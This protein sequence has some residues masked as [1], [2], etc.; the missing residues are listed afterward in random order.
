MNRK[1]ITIACALFTLCA[2]PVNGQWALVWEDDFT[3]DPFGLPDSSKWG[4]E[5]GF[6]RNNELQYYTVARTE[7]ARVENGML[8]IEGRKESYED[9]NYTSASMITKN[10]F[11]FTYG[12]VEME[13]KLPQGLGV[14]PALWTMGT[15]GI[16]P[17]LGEIDIMEYVGKAPHTIYGTIHWDDGG[18]RSIGGTYTYYYPYDGFHLYA[19]EWFPDHI[20]WYFDSIKYFTASLAN[21]NSGFDHP[22]FILLNLALGGSWGGSIDDNCLPVQ[23]QVKYVRV[24]A[25]DRA[26]LIPT[27]ILIS[28]EDIVN[29]PTSGR[30]T[31]ACTA[32]V[33]DQYGQTM[34][35][36]N[37]LWSLESPVTGISVDSSSGVISVDS[38]ADFGYFT[39]L[40]TDSGVTGQLTILATSLPYYE[41][42]VDYSSTQGQNQWYYRY[43]K[44]SASY[45]MTWDSANNRWKG[46]ET[47]LLLGNGTF[48]PGENGDAVLDWIAPQSGTVR[49]CG[50]V[51]KSNIS[52][53]DGIVATIRRNGDVVWGP[54]SIAYNDSIGRSHD[55][56]LNVTAN[57]TLHFMV[58]KNSANNG[59]DGT[60]WNPRIYYYDSTT[61]GLSTTLSF[62]MESFT[63]YPNPFNP[64]VTMRFVLGKPSVVAIHVF[65]ISGKRI[66]T[67]LKETCPAGL[68]TRVWNGRDMNGHSLPS[69]IY[70]IHFSTPGTNES[71]QVLFLK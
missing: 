12:R 52:C 22:H 26:E 19:V 44:G 66:A 58:N 46:D 56:A 2:A 1:F 45:A 17:A 7:N 3:T 41:Y 16:W 20:D 11:S 9:A 5:S 24:Y 25:L 37:I 47:Y 21:T 48:H 29:I 49:V 18:H 10:K 68:Q 33:K 70:L 4:Y 6:V 35:G 59:C 71:R 43:L 23:Y 8:I 36:R 14:W 69:G 60:R 34:L 53:G 50:T 67:L 57:D 54:F 61:V 15:T 13:A 28:G 65:D 63:V 64:T 30:M 42:S 31:T 51:R 32:T 38:S 39:L 40:A 55:F 62:P 27:T